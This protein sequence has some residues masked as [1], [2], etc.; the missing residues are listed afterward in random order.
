MRL[1]FWEKN[2]GGDATA[3]MRVLLS[4]DGGDE[5]TASEPQTCCCLSKKKNGCVW[6]AEGVSIALLQAL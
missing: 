6:V 1:L 3:T 2:E 4:W 5:E